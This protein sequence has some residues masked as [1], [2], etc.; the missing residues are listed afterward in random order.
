MSGEN[1][2]DIKTL[3]SL[4]FE[5]GERANFIVEAFVAELSAE[6]YRLGGVIQLTEAAQSCDCRDTELRNV[7]TGQTFS[8]LQ[9][10]GRQSQSCRVDPGA[11][12]RAAGEIAGA[13]ERSPDLLFI[14]RFGKL[15][16]E[17]KGLYAEIGAA[18]MAG[19]PTLVCVPMR[20]LGAWRNFTMGLDE[21]LPCSAE[22]LRRWWSAF[23]VGGAVATIR[24]GAAS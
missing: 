19:V 5:D 7:E 1:R 21:E 9:D 15:E 6:G 11:I 18:A 2:P 24:A 3:A 22:A 13:L 8:I 12:A 17:G 20:F 16:I 23:A 14:N 10:L 4:V